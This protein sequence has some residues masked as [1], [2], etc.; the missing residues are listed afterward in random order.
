ML[1]IH[2]V[3]QEYNVINCLCCVVLFTYVVSSVNLSTFC[4][5]YK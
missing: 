5:K 1:T 3:I 4:F 2:L